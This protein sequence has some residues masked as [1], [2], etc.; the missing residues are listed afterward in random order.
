MIRKKAFPARRLALQKACP[1]SAGNP[2]FPG[3]LSQG[4][5]HGKMP[6]QAM[7]RDGVSAKSDFVPAPPGRYYAH[8]PGAG[9]RS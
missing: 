7:E 1:A 2:A 3:D 6:G 5:L 9:C 4:P 8:L